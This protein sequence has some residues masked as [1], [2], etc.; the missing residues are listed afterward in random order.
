MSERKELLERLGVYSKTLT[1]TKS[2][3]P[4]LE[5]GKVI[6]FKVSPR[7]VEVLRS[8][9]VALGH[10]VSNL[11]RSLMERD[12]FF[13]PLREHTTDVIILSV[14][15]L[16]FKGGAE[17]RQIRMVAAEL[18]LWPCPAQIAL[19]LRAVYG[20][21]PKYEVVRIVMGTIPFLGHY[22]NIGYGIFMMGRDS[23][24][25]WLGA[26]EIR[27]DDFFAP[28]SLFAFVRPPQHKLLPR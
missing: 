7:E 23:R 9:L 25:C 14:G 8:A 12:T 24:K 2:T 28:D 11:A 21:Q 5:K 15:D 17:F 13:T 20:N 26:D 4:S 6:S 19:A 10:P 1:V 18:P 3:V 27:P 22:K 16:G